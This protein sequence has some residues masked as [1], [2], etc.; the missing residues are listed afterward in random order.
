[1]VLTFHPSYSSVHK[2]M[3]FPGRL[4]LLL[5]TDYTGCYRIPP[6]VHRTPRDVYALLTSLQVSPLSGPQP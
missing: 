5:A 2:I 4:T 3:R 1:M 6:E